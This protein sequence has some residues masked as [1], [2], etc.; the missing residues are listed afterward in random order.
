MRGPQGLGFGEQGQ[1]TSRD[2]AFHLCTI[3]RAPIRVSYFVGV[4]FA[5]QLTEIARK[6]RNNEI[7]LWEVLRATGNEAVLLLTVL[8]HEF[9]HGNMARY[10]GGDISQILLWV[11]GGICFHSRPQTDSIDNAKLLRNDLLVVA[12]GPSTH[13]L[14]VAVWGML[15][16]L[17]FQWITLDKG[18][19]GYD[20]AYDAFLAALYPL[21]Y[22]LQ[23]EYVWSSLGKWRA[24]I[25]SLVGSAIQLNSALFIFNVFFPMYPADG[26][27]LLVTS[28]M[29]FFGVRPRRAAFVLLCASVPCA[30]LMIG[31]SVYGIVVRGAGGMLGGLMGWMGVMSLMEANSIWK[32]YKA[33][34]LHQHPLFQVARSWRRQDRDAFGVV[35]RLNHSDFDDD[36]PLTIGGFRGACCAFGIPRA[37]CSGLCGESGRFRCCCPFGARSPLLES[38]GP[39]EVP[40]S[41]QGGDVRIQRGR[42]MTQVEQQQAER[43]RSVRNMLDERGDRSGGRPSAAVGQ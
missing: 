2:C 1:Q 35:H 39:Q 37:R 17:I 28:L 15:L 23:Y 22:G 19:S 30:L 16:W 29:F 12:A 36:A 43:M 6:G 18:Y 9:G 8:C 40:V 32:L 20:S 24:L 7:L 31:Y 26:A 3:C 21:G 34:L 27:K 10:L 41:G 42:L 33:R 38:P 5:Y 4:F 14:Q 13:F 25:L 11:F